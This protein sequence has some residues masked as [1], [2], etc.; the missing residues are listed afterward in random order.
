MGVPFVVENKQI[1]LSI[2]TFF[3]KLFIAFIVLV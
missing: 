1:F 3:Y 2:T